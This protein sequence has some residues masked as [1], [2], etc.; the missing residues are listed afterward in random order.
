VRVHFPTGGVTSAHSHAGESFDVNPFTVLGEL[1]G[2]DLPDRLQGLVIPGRDTVRITSYPFHGFCDYADSQGGAGAL[3]KGIREYEIV[4]PSREIALTLLRSVGWMTHL[5]ILTRNGDVGWEI[6]CPNAQCYGTHTF[7]Y[8]FCP[9]RGDWFAGKV[10]VESDL[11]NEPVR[12]VQTSAHAGKLPVRM[13]FASITPGEKLV[14]SMTKLSEDGKALIVR[15]YN[16]RDTKV[17]GRVD[18]AAK[19]TKACKSNVAEECTGQKLPKQGKGYRFSAGKRK[20]VT[21]RFELAADASLARKPAASL[22]RATKLRPIELPVAEPSLDIPLPAAVT[23]GE[24]ESEQRRLA[25]I[26]RRHKQ[27][28]ARHAA[29]GKRVRAM[30]KKGVEDDDLLIEWSKLGH[31]VALE[32]RY[33]DEAKFSVLLTQRRWYEQT[34]KD[35]KRLKALMKRTQA[36]IAKTELPELRIIGRLHEYVRQFYVSRKASKLGKGLTDMAKE[37]TDAALANTAQQSMAARR[38]K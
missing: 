26:R 30:A 19:V 27:L 10:H 36:G 22:A 18:V 1:W 17:T 38:N 35:P 14:H 12:V 15:C 6:Y 11:F 23:K 32:R 28:K 13:S 37:V 34:V 29:L 16:P 2:I 33:I 20:I 24:I 8:G 25:K 31:L 3:A 5:D 21:L 9:H 4:K 7:R